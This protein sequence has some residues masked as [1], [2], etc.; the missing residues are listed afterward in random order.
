MIPR[1][2]NRIVSGTAAFLEAAARS[3][4][5][6]GEA[7]VAAF[8]SEFASRSVP[9]VSRTSRGTRSTAAPLRRR[10][11]ALLA[12]NTKQRARLVLDQHDAE[13]IARAR[14]KLGRIRDQRARE[15]FFETF[16]NW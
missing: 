15:R 16:G 5:P 4:H 3:R 8:A 7:F 2:T 14:A 11:R 9:R 6:P 12:A 1:V 13:M 10:A